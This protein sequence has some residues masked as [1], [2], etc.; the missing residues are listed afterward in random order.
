[1]PCASLSGTPGPQTT[2]LRQ[3]ESGGCPR[4]V[5]RPD[6]A[7]EISRKAEVIAPCSGLYAPCYRKNARLLW[8]YQSLQKC[9]FSGPF[10]ASW[11]AKSPKQARALRTPR[12]M[13]FGTKPAFSADRMSPAWPLRHLP[14][15]FHG[16][17]LKLKTA[18]FRGFAEVGFGGGE[19]FVL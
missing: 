4:L 19:K 18:G 7:K 12:M 6:G 17:V 8:S 5:S 13:D 14:V 3:P 2:G 1:M 10:G 9:P 11:I 15:R 16:T